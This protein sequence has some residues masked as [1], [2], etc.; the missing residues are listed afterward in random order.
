MHTWD[1]V[2][3]EEGVALPSSSTDADC[4]THAP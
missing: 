3:F 1:N 2:G 4:Y